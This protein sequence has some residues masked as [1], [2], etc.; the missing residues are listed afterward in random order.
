MESTQPA[1][2]DDFFAHCGELLFV[3]DRAGTLVRLSAPLAHLL[4]VSSG[5]G[6]K[7]SDHVHADD[8]AALEGAWSRLDA[9]AGAPFELRIHGADGA[10]R[11]VACRAQRADG[12]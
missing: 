10:Y 5:A 7:L 1:S 12:G 6:E 8:R 9:G 11:S 3:A 4:G 2:L